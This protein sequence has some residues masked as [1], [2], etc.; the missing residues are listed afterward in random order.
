[1]RNINH[2]IVRFTEAAVALALITAAPAAFAAGGAATPPMGWNPYNAFGINANEANIMA[3]AE[4]LT[5]TG[6]AD[7]GYRY[8]NVD[9]G[10]WLKRGAD[11]R[12]VVRTSMFPS[13]AP[14][15]EGGQTSLRPFTDKLH[16]MGFKAGLYTDIGRNACSQAWQRKNPNLPEGTQ[17]EREVGS[18]D[19][20][21]GDMQQIFGDWNFDYIKVDACG[22]ADYGP[23]RAWVK[24]GTYRVFTPTIV[25]DKPNPADDAKVEALYASLSDAIAAVRPKGDYVLSICAWG[26]ASTNEWGN[27]HGNLWRTSA[28]INASWKSMLHNFDSA[29]AIPDKA[30]PGHWNDPD[31]LEIGNGEF[32]ASHLTEARAHMSMWAMISA[33]LLLGSDVAKWPQSLVDIA[34]NREVIAID[35]DPLGRQGTIV[36]KTGDGE[37]LVKS[38]ANGDKAV[39]LINRSNQPISLSVNRAQLELAKGAVTQRDLWTHKDAALKGDSLQVAL[40]PHETALYRLKVKKR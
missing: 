20:Q 35:Q 5:K 3:T 14:A 2:G 24:D 23:D 19:H 22:L 33:P 4:A 39:A 31:M 32:D 16:A 11:G 36:S 18:L 28:D 12:V 37:I 7:A 25:R 21:A 15:A 13:A 1:M 8:I 6:L 38:L 9:D 40:A 10:W 29:A 30:G 26:E 34:G 27:K 17:A